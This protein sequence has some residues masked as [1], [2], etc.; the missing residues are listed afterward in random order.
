VKMT[1]RNPGPTREDEKLWGPEQKM[2]NL[3]G[4]EASS[5]PQRNWCQGPTCRR[6]K[7]LDDTGSIT[8]EGGH[9]MGHNGPRTVGLGRLAWPI[10]GSIRRPLWPT[11]SQTIYSPLAK[12][13]ISTI[14]HSPPRS[15]REGH[16]SGE[17]RVELVV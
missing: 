11:R 5:K 4:Q 13:H 10:S 8:E 17:E 15:R 1:P 9:E 14:R 3:A 2:L 7:L 6:E 12:S 16:H